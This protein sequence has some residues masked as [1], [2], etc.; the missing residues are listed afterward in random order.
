M[1]QQT[2]S[3][4]SLSEAVSLVKAALSNQP[5]VPALSHLVFDGASV[6]A[7]NDI[8]AISVR[9]EV[10]LECCVP[11]EL[12]I[13]TLSSL[14]GSEVVL[15]HSEEALVVACG[16]AKVKLPTLPLDVFPFSM[17]E[18]EGKGLLLNSSILQGIAACLPGSGNDPTHPAQMGVTMSPVDDLI[19]LY[20]TDN[21]T[22]S[23]YLANST[24]SIPGD[25]PIILPMFFCQQLLS[26]SKAYQNQV[27]RLMVRPDF[28]LAEV[29]DHVSL[30]TKVAVQVEPLDFERVLS[31]HLG[32]EDD[33]EDALREIPDGFDAAIDRALMVVS[34]DIDKAT[35]ITLAKGKMKLD[36]SSGTAEASDSFAYKSDFEEEVHV[37]PTFIA[38]S[39]KIGTRMAILEDSLIITDGGSFLHLIS[40]QRK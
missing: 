3:R 16:R 2:V 19:G 17:P 8:S 31:K 14:G 40:Y 9:T 5:F 39:L 22:I 6:T 11:G 36:T 37:D 27:V 13:K 28:L 12:L 25:V 18:F 23:R 20:S 21:F 35:T 10:D 4:S 24:I 1:S 7:Y 30:Y 33:L 29:G 26:L 32:S 38:R 34:S 15:T